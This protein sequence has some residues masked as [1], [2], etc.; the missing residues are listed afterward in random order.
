MN[1]LLGEM[2]FSLI[3]LTQGLDGALNISES[4]EIL[5]ASIEVNVLPPKWALQTNPTKKLLNEWFTE[6]L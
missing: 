1:T 4:M 5:Q 6:L 2:R 3:E